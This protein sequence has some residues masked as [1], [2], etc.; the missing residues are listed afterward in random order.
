MTKKYHLFPFKNGEI[1]YFL[2]YHVAP[3]KTYT[4]W[5]GGGKNEEKKCVISPRRVMT[6]YRPLQLTCHPF[7]ALTN[8]TV[9]TS[10]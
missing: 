8:P 4:F 6:A 10:L 5:G 3:N 9:L 2:I 7:P 1:L